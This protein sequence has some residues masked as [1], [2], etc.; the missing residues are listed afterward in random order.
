MREVAVM[1]EPAGTLT[2][3]SETDQ[4]VADPG[5]DVRGRTVIDSAGEN[6]GTVADLLVD[7]AEG[8]VR[9]LKVEHGGIL[10]FGAASSFIPVDSVR[11]VTED[12]VHVDSSKDRIAGAPKYDPELVEQRGYYEQI[13]GYYGYPPYWAPGHLY[14]GFPL[15]R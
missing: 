11:R 1:S 3:L 15:G 9:F 13:Y 10:G 4:M 8:K 7:N 12:E 6:V 2:P 14:P 5:D